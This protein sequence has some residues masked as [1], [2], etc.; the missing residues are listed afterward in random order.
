MVLDKLGP[1]ERVAFV[2]HDVFGVPFDEVAPIVGRSPAATRQLASRARRRVRGSTVPDTDLEGQ[3]AVVDAFVV[4]ARGGDLSALLAALDPD[5]L[6][7]ADGGTSPASASRETRG[8]ATVAQLVLAYAGRLTGTLELAVVNGAA[9]VVALDSDRRPLSV[10]GFTISRAKIVEIDILADPA[11]L[12]RL[13]VS[14]LTIDPQAPS[15]AARR[16]RAAPSLMSLILRN[17]LFNLVVPGLGAGFIPWSILAG[18]H[19]TPT[20]AAWPA[21]A[22]IAIG[23]A[24]YLSC[25]AVFAGVGRGTPGPWDAPRQLVAV[26]PY[27]WVRNPIYIAALLVV[28]GEAWLFMSLPL[29]EYAGAMA[30]AVHLFV[31]WYEEP[32]LGRRFGEAYADYR[33]TVRRWIPRPP[34]HA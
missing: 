20:P 2:L 32:T 24:L 14:A 11:R 34:R 7:R 22:V 27:R 28:I 33:R 29:L 31:I 8:A 26:G 30:V 16:G 1:A 21:V 3:R 23:A 13:D 17:L 10:L 6:L 25:Q 18:D 9:G 4:A 12:S 15:R 19:R 5:V